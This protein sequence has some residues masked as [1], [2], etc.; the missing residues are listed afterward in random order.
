MQ[1]PL[2]IAIIGSGISG[3]GAAHAL[4]RNRNDQHGTHSRNTAVDLHIDVYEAQSRVGGHTHTHTLEVDGI[5][6]HVDSGFIVLNDRNYPT[7]TDFLAD[8][9][10]PTTDTRMSFAVSMATDKD[11]PAYLEYAGSNLS[12]LCGGGRLAF[13]L[14]HLKMLAGIAQFNRLAKRDLQANLC[15]SLCLADYLQQHRISDDVQQRYLL[16]MAAAIWS[17]PT[18]AIK[19]FPAKT[20]LTFFN[21]HGLLDIRNRPQWKTVTGGSQRYIDALVKRPGFNLHTEHALV[22]ATPQ[23]NGVQLR[24]ANGIEKHVDAVIFS[25]H[26]D[27]MFATFN[28]EQQQQFAALGQVSYGDNTAYLHSDQ[29]FL[30]QNSSLWSCWNYLSHGSEAASDS[31]LMVS[32]WM[33]ELQNLPCTTPIIVTLN[34]TYEPDTDKT[35]AVMNYSHPIFDTAAVQAQETIQSYQGQSGCYFAGAYLRYGF[36]EDGVRSG[37][38]AAECLIADIHSGTFG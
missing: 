12:T 24:F 18:E 1:K 34:P 5:S 3:L 20:F 30:P 6:T 9:E 19:A 37:Y 8:L 35:Y 16:P 31:P 14:R 7:F 10:V 28:T 29:R 11:S 38:Q 13:S 21:H 4:F 17:C 25:G 15:D 33:N 26:A 32:Y 2:K 23:Q 22:S 27:Q 36:H